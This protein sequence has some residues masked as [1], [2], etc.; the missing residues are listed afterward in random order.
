ME[1]RFGDRV[2]VTGESTPGVSGAFEV[3]LLLA[4]GG[5]RML[6]SKKNGDGFVDTNDKLEKI[7]QQVEEALKA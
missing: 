5:E 2:T 7:F 1:K 4:D 6:H 3:L